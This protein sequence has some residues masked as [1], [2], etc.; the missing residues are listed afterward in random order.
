MIKSPYELSI[1]A[2]DVT[3]HRFTR[4]D[5][6]RVKAQVDIFLKTPLEQVLLGDLQL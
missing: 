2:A 1:N 6:L 3:S 4:V 5:R